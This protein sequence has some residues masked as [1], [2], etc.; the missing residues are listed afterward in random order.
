MKEQSIQTTLQNLE[1]LWDFYISWIIF[2]LKT[3]FTI[4]SFLYISFYFTLVV[5]KRK[6]TF[7]KLCFSLLNFN[8]MRFSNLN[9]F[10]QTMFF[11]FKFLQYAFFNHKLLFTNYMFQHSY[12]TR[13]I[14]YL[15]QFQT[16]FITLHF[17]L[18]QNIFT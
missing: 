16:C 18:R 10:S 7:Y 3:C 9:Y 2:Q 4:N 11:T 14:F 1:K 15:L 6:K 17:T 13:I 8:N 5:F 12:I